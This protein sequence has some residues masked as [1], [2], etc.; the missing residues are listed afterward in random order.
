MVTLS[1]V[2][3]NAPATAGT[4]VPHT[5]IYNPGL[6]FPVANILTT[7]CTMLFPMVKHD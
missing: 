7:A 6:L 4:Q 1:I 3:I 2:K 5:C